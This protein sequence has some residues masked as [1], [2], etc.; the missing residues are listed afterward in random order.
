M[1]RK[2]CEQLS[3]FLVSARSLINLHSAASVRSFFKCFCRSFIGM[4]WSGLFRPINRDVLQLPPVHFRTK[5][6]SIGAQIVTTKAATSGVR[7]TGQHLP[8]HTSQRDNKLSSF[9]LE[10]SSGR[11]NSCAQMLQAS[12]G[13]ERSFWTFPRRNQVSV[14]H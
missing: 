6:F 11:P 4:P 10:K 8:A 1:I 3:L 9:E 2:P 13:P 7:A 12:Q 5:Q 14:A